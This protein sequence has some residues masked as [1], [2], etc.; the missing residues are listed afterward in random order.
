M[1]N[2]QLRRRASGLQRTITGASD[3]SAWEDAGAGEG[4]PD[5][6]RD[7]LS[8]I[9]ALTLDQEILYLSTAL[10]DQNDW[11][12]IAFTESTVVRV[13]MVRGS[14]APAHTE[15]SVFP[16]S[17]LQSLELVEVAPI[18]DNNDPWPSNMHLIGH[19]TSATVTLPLDRFASNDNKREL[20]QLLTSL[21]QDVSH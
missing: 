11:D 21:L 10:P 7:V 5:W 15:T 6:Q 14:G 8:K 13:L 19:Y 9:L 2:E 17:S 3:S 18:P 4:V 1:D 20:V 12:I 16:R